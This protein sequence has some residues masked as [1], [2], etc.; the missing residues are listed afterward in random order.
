MASF[1][2]ENLRYGD[3]RRFLLH[4]DFE[5]GPNCYWIYFQVYRRV[6][7]NARFQETGGIQ[8]IQFLRLAGLFLMA[9]GR[10]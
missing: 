8:W 1:A 5:V 4:R 6:Y 9:C 3:N 2:V 7:L 10:F